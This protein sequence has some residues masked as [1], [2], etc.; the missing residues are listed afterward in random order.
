[1]KQRESKDREKNWSK[2]IGRMKK[3]KENKVKKKQ[4][5]SREKV[6]IELKKVKIKL[7][8]NMERVDSRE[9]NS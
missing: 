6:K 3:K 9:R 4:K 5:Q 8:Q 2:E 7:R 1:M